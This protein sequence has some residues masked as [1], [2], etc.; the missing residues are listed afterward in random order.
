MFILHKY[1]HTGIVFFY[2]ELQQ[3]RNF[4]R[5][6]E[7]LYKGA[8]KVLSFVNLMKL[9]GVMAKVLD[10]NIVVS[11]FELLSSYH[12]HF[13][14]NTLGKVMYPLILTNYAL[15]CTPLS[16]TIGEYYKMW[17]NELFILELSVF[18]ILKSI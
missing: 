1:A 12:A 2:S 11:E 4:Q 10:W 5:K 16:F 8:S 18:T 14:T 17:P 15:N 13:Q 7:K 9:Y 3:F 6:L